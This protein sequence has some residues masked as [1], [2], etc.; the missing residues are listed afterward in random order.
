MRTRIA[1]VMAV[2]VASL[3]S[4]PAGAN[5]ASCTIS[6]GVGPGDCI[7]HCEVGRVVHVAFT[8]Y[9]GFVTGS[10]SGAYA[11]CDINPVTNGAGTTYCERYSDSTVVGDT[12]NGLCH[13][14][15][16]AHELVTCS[17]E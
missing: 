4:R 1:A 9:F 14:D 16:L 3:L 2:A 13:T 15:G 8:G 17:S 12:H 7:F 6:A 11:A 5:G 10:C